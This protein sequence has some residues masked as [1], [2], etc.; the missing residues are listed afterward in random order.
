MAR[1]LPLVRPRNVPDSKSTSHSAMAIADS[2][3]AIQG[4]YNGAYLTE[5]KRRQ[6]ER[7]AMRRQAASPSGTTLP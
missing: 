3:L 4:R 2:I 7:Q 5:F 1:G 6:T